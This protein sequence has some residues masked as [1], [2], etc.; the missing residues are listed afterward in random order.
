LQDSN[1]FIECQLPNGNY[2]LRLLVENTKGFDAEAFY[3][4]LS[5]AVVMREVAWKQVSKDTGVSQSTLS[6]MAQGRQ[7]DAGSLA[8][9]AS[10]AGLDISDFVHIQKRPAEAIS[11]VGR[12]LRQDPNL[13]QKGAMA[14]EA[15]FRT[16][17]EQFRLRPLKGEE[18]A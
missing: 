4:A 15:I 17:Y 10:W 7:P 5:G 3:R 6:R 12:L 16:A 13:D 14:L 18:E 2:Y 8:S 11:G 1:C 9:L